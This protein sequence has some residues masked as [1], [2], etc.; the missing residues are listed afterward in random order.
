MPQTYK[1][2]VGK[3]NDENYSDNLLKEAFMKI[4]EGRMNLLKE[5]QNS[6]KF[7]SVLCTIKLWGTHAPPSVQDQY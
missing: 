3:K 1:T 5:R 6:I 2:K 4:V 7:L